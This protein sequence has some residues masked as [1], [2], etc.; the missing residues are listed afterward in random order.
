MQLT[1]TRLA[2]LQAVSLP[3]QGEGWQAEAGKERHDEA[4]GGGGGGLFG[5]D[6]MQRAAGEAALRQV[7]I[8]GGKAK[9]MGL[10]A[11]NPSILGNNRRNSSATAARLRITERAVGGVMIGSVPTGR[12]TRTKQEQCQDCFSQA[13]HLTNP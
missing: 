3:L 7:P 10:A 1:P 2:V 6:L 13:G 5:H 11:R 12:H 4:E 8:D 9:G